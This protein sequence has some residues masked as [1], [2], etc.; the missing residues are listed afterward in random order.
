MLT[1]FQFNHQD[2]TSK[3][4]SFDTKY[5]LPGSLSN[6]FYGHGYDS[7]LVN[8]TIDSYHNILLTQYPPYIIQPITQFTKNYD[9]EV[10]FY[11]Y[12]GQFYPSLYDLC[13]NFTQ[14]KYEEDYQHGDD[15]LFNKKIQNHPWRVKDPEEASVFI[16]PALL[17]FGARKKDTYIQCGSESSPLYYIQTYELLK[18]LSSNIVKSKY[19]KLYPTRHLIVASHWILR[20]N[21]GN[22]FPKKIHQMMKPIT[23]GS[24]EVYNHTD[25]Q[26]KK[27]FYHVNQ[28]GTAK[29]YQC[30]IVTPYVDKSIFY[31]NPVPEI[32]GKIPE[33]SFDHWKTRK[34]QFSFIGR[35]AEAYFPYKFRFDLANNLDQLED[36]LR[37]KN[38]GPGDFRYV[39]AASTNKFKGK[40]IEWPNCNTNASV[41]KTCVLDQAKN[42]DQYLKI[43]ANSRFGLMLAGDT[44]STGRLY[45]IIS[46]GSIP[47]ILSKYLLRDG[48]PFVD[49]VP[50]YRFCYFVDEQQEINKIY[51]DLVKIMTETSMDEYLD[52][53]L[54]LIYYSKDILWRRENSR[55]V[56]NLIVNAAGG[57]NQ[58]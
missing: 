21:I 10:P 7:H 16:I 22:K 23:V 57:C 37:Q 3:N 25:L 4:S 56:E 13:K 2:L 33:L 42:P 47:I 45:D 51:A 19:F 20:W 52:K 1:I 34:F 55:V 6:L 15:I 35:F 18:T 38:L 11:V 31:Q 9:L 14:F 32:D 27:N 40:T 8:T 41:L 12:S 24:Y 26:L 44:P 28:Q 39:F 17:A 43:L 48:L 49:K 5:P 54:N 29:N 36:L 46:S 53:Y 30:S 58:D 50:Y